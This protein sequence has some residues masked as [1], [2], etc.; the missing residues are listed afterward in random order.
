MARPV[1]RRLAARI[2]RRI[3]ERLANDDLRTA[4]HQHVPAF[5][6]ATASVGAVAREQAHMKR[7]LAN[8]QDEIGRIWEATGR[9]NQDQGHLWKRVEFVRSELLYEMRYGA[10]AA[11][12][13]GRPEAAP[14]APKIVA[15]EKVRGA[16]AEGLRL[17]LGC[18]HIPLDGYIN[19]DMRELPGVDLVARVDALPFE[20]G[21]VAEIFSAHVLEHFTKQEL[22]R[23]LL[24]YWAGL[25]KPGGTFRAVVPDAKAM[26]QRAARGEYDFEDFRQVFFGAQDYDGDFHLNMFTAE[27]IAA[28]LR[29]AGLEAVEV[30]AEG[31]K[32]D[33]AFELEVAG[34]VPRQ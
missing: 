1:W 24:P 8:H 26:I 29:G 6:N 16:R 15:T 34:R 3:D 10:G 19:V 30:I 11:A 32:N 33:N 28:A 5:L 18:G 20:R 14:A 23:R 2:D 12:P 4:W 25:L 27:S 17:N 13:G 9:I 22:E 31:R 7:Q 21:E